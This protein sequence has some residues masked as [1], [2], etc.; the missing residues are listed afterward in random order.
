MSI[1][2][3]VLQGPSASGKSTIQSRLGLPRIVTWTSRSPRE[4][5]SDGV[6]YHFK[7]RSE[8]ERLYE[9]GQMLEMTEYHG[10]LYGTP[11][12]LIEETV[13]D[14]EMKSMILDGAGSR[15]VKAMFRDNV[16]LIGIKASKEDCEKRLSLRGHGFEEIRTRLSSFDREIAELSHCDVIL[17]NTDDNK[18]KID[19][20][21]DFIRE[22]L[23]K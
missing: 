14:S 23:G 21:T 4:G 11:L 22:G 3:V 19:M 13:R 6:D 5:E 20:L 10:N 8:M 17:N 18:G 7:S 2:L 1:C 9:L 16:L 15:K 12:K